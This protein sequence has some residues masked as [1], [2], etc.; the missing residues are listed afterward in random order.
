[1]DLLPVTS[2]SHWHL[3]QA[4]IH[5]IF[6]FSRHFISNIWF[7]KVF[8]V[9]D[10]LLLFLNIDIHCPKCSSFEMQI[11]FFFVCMILVLYLSNYCI[12]LGHKDVLLQCLLMVLK[13]SLLLIS[14]LSSFIDCFWVR[15]LNYG[16]LII[17][18][19]VMWLNFNIFYG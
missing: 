8:W 4:L 14:L 5:Y 3:M 17:L 15:G 11:H 19:M 13:F 1:M 9:S 6:S 10:L 16:S 7:P 2:L 12:F 18:P